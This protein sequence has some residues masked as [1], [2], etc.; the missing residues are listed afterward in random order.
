MK[1]LLSILLC[2]ALLMSLC[3][4][5]QPEEPAPADPPAQNE[6]EVPVV[7]P[8]AAQSPDPEPLVL[9]SADRHP[10]T[11]AWPEMQNADFWIAQAEDPT[12]LRMTEE[13]IRAYNA[14]IVNAYETNTED[15]ST[16]PE[17]L[18]SAPGMASKI[19]T[20]MQM[21]PLS[22]APMPSRVAPLVQP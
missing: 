13:E 18:N 2:A 16:W 19:C 20:A 1:R 7:T 11:L 22:H 12:A 4:C 17:V 5:S 10:L 6:P 14:A 8:P 3:A 9:E 21:A 15:L